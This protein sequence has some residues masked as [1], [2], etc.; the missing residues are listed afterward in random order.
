LAVS[1]SL[2]LKQAHTRTMSLLISLLMS[3]ALAAPVSAPAAPALECS[4]SVQSKASGHWLHFK[5]RNTGN[6]VVWLLNWGSPFE[7]QW[8]APFVT[9]Y[10][11]G[12]A[13]PYAGAKAKRGEPDAADYLR[14]AP[15]QTRQTKL[16][17]DDAFEL[18]G[19]GPWR[20]EAQWRWHDVLQGNSAR[21]PRSREH[22]QAMEQ[23]CGSVTLN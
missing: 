21:P 22:H 17:L 19:A 16:R 23:A 5:L 15:G 4:M 11:N 6:T 2:H 13:L 20:V 7:G 3:S 1:P 14:L 10:Q 9:V 8:W 12:Q 18:S